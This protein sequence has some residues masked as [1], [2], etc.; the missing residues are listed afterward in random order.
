MVLPVDLTFQA[1]NSMRDHNL[2]FFV[3]NQGMIFKCA[4]AR[5]GNLLIGSHRPVVKLNIEFV[6]YGFDPIDPFCHFL[7]GILFSKR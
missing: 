3:G 1:H 4:Q 7:G 6:G 2:E 5:L